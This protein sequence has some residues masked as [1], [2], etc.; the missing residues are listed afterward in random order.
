MLRFSEAQ[1]YLSDS[2]VIEF[3][4]VPLRMDDGFVLTLS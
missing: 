3:L 1:S 4:E 2:Q